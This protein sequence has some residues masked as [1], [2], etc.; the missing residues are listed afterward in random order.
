MS[1]VAQTIEDELQHFQINKRSVGNELKVSDIVSFISVFSSSTVKLLTWV[2][3]IFKRAKGT[4]FY[5]SI[6]MALF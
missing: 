3:I 4:C 2:G 5:L 1:P 6:L